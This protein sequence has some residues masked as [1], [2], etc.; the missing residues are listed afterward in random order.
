MTTAEPV[1]TKMDV[2]ETTTEA[3][4]ATM[5]DEMVTM[6]EA[7]LNKTSAG[8]ITLMAEPVTTA[9]PET[10][11][12]VEMTMRADER[13][14]MEAGM[15]LTTTKV[16]LVMTTPEAPATT[17]SGGLV[18]CNEAKPDPDTGQ[19]HWHVSK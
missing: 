7:E 18:K 8:P 2:S 14:T 15:D 9:G 3:V 5:A 13:M 12:K 1:T 16:L 11:T 10:T 17:S 6:M 4:V 19:V